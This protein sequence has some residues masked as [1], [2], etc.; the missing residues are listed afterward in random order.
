[1]DTPDVE[2]VADVVEQRTTVRRSEDVRRVAALG[3]LAVLFVGWGIAWA[4]ASAAVARKVDRDEFTRYVAEAQRRFQTDSIE[5][6]HD[7]ESST[8]A[9][10]RIESKVDSTNQRLSRLICERGPSYCR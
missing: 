5:R 8:N 1:M 4:T 7:R 10:Q 6:I 9:L 2:A 3:A